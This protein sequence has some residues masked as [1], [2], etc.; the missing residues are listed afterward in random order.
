MQT[1]T[2]IETAELERWERLDGFAR[3]ALT[4]ILAG[5]FEIQEMPSLDAQS[6]KR[7]VRRAWELARR[8]EARRTE[9]LVKDAERLLE[10]TE[11]AA[12]VADG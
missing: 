8:M 3:A 9:E 5:H 2:D 10:Q 4:G 11:P 12:S 1:A 7:I 6:Q